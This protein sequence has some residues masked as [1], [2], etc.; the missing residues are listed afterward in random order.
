MQLLSL[1]V[2]LLYLVYILSDWMWFVL[3]GI[4]FNVAFHRLIASWKLLLNQ[5]L[6]RLFGVAFL[7]IQ[8]IAMGFGVSVKYSIVLWLGSLCASF[9]LHFLKIFPN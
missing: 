5:G 4:F 6:F 7:G 1:Y 8:F 9:Y 3:F 2:S